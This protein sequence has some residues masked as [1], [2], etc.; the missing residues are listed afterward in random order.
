MQPVRTAASARPLPTPVQLW[1]FPFPR[2]P[3]IG[4]RLDRDIRILFAVACY[5]PVRCSCQRTQVTGHCARL[6]CSSSAVRARLMSEA[7]DSAR[8]SMNLHGHLLFTCGACPSRVLT[9]RDQRSP[10]GEQI[11]FLIAEEVERRPLRAESEACN[12]QLEP[13]FT[14][15][16]WLE[17]RPATPV[18]ENQHQMSD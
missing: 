3:L 18:C 16:Q 6:S 5:P 13:P 1:Y 9:N 12:S 11:G 8:Y 14:P 15:Q 2:S 7:G 4:L 10:V 17:P